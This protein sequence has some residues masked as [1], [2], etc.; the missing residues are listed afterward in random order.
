MDKRL[1]TI[2]TLMKD[3]S[4]EELSELSTSI[5]TLTRNNCHK[6]IMDTVESHKKYVGKCYILKGYS[7]HNDMLTG[8]KPNANKYFKI[9]SER[10]TNEYHMTALT[11]PENPEYTFNPHLHK[12]YFPGDGFCGKIT[13]SGIDVED[14]GFF[15]NDL[16]HGGQKIDQFEEISLEEYNEAFDKFYKQLKELQITIND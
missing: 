9:I 14:V 13:L 7:S 1:E 15:C 8:K 5:N 11:F 2:R 16:Q 3:L 10:A 4:Q 6:N 12:M